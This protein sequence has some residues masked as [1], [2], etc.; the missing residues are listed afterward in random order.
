MKKENTKQMDAKAFFKRG[1]AYAK[2]GNH[3]QAAWDYGKVIGMKPD[4]AD[5]YNNRG[6]AN[7]EQ[8][9]CI[10]AIADFSAAI[11]I[12]PNDPD[13]YFN[14]GLAHK[15]AFHQKINSKTRMDRSIKKGLHKATEDFM[16]AI[17]LDSSYGELP[18]T[19][20][21]RPVQKNMFE[22]CLTIYR[23]KSEFA[24]KEKVTNDTFRSV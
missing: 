1:L 3:A 10:R 9:Y 2:Q 4:H 23:V 12:N 15:K 19:T 20:V 13:F 21:G 11:K 14:R 6:V 17:K 24:Q 16:K 7:A 5:A 18:V 22:S 8:G